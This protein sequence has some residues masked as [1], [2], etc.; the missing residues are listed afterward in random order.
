MS[1]R[2]FQKERRKA[3]RDLVKRSGRVSDIITGAGTL[4]LRKMKAGFGALVGRVP[5]ASKWAEQF[6]TPSDI[7][8]GKIQGLEEHLVELRTQ[9]D[10]AQE[11]VSEIQSDIRRFHHLKQRASKLW[12]VYAGSDGEP[13][14]I[15][16][17]GEAL[18][19]LDEQLVAHQYDAENP[20]SVITPEV[21]AVLDER[22]PIAERLAQYKRFAERH[23]AR[24]HHYG[25]AIEGLRVQRERRL[26]LIEAA[27]Q[28]IMAAQ[29]RSYTLHREQPNLESDL[30]LLGGVHGTH[31]AEQD[32]NDTEARIIYMI[33]QLTED[34][35]RVVEES[36]E[37]PIP[38]E[39]LAYSDRVA[40]DTK[41]T[42]QRIAAEAPTQPALAA[43][44][45]RLGLNPGATS[46]EV[47]E[48]HRRAAQEQH[49]DKGGNGEEY[50]LSTEARD[51]LMAEGVRGEKGRQ[52]YLLDAG[53]EAPDDEP[54]ATEE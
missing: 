28:K 38:P 26:T 5:G 8:A 40:A 9:R 44:Y 45:N 20:N 32:A 34:L 43:A 19:A 49:P 14:L 53:P 4:N 25:H 54:G 16:K 6:T 11:Q 15:A 27:D 30:R 18:S 37:A 21:A 13:G 10:A 50:R 51:I 35:H 7:L 46:A 12:P 36:Y 47:D 22:G 23:K 3:T 29:T 42:L 31:A 17:T 24:I 33:T 52:R 1:D 48:A 41:Q 39:V 2:G